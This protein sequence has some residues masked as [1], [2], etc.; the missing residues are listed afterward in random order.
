[1][2]GWVKWYRDAEINPVLEDSE[3][4]DRT[5]AFLWMVMRANYKRVYITINGRRRRLDRGQFLTSVRKLAAAWGWG[6]KKVTKFLEELESNA[7]ITRKRYHGGTIITV[8]NYSKFQDAGNSLGDTSDHANDYANGTQY[9]NIKRTVAEPRNRGPL[10]LEEVDPRYL[11]L[12][13]GE[14]DKW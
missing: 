8:E 6:T 14:P 3:G 10:P 5:H 12:P 9:K 11:D 7:M 2:A 1:M 4:F 13:M